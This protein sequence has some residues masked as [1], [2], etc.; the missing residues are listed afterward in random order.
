LGK[1][2]GQSRQRFGYL[3]ENTAFT[4]STFAV[5]LEEFG[6]ISAI[7]VIGLWIYF[8]FKGF[9]I[10]QNAP[11]T[12][13]KLIA[14]GITIWL[15]LQALLNIAANIGIIPITG[16][17]LPFFTYG[18]SSTIVTFIS[19]ALLLNIS[20]YGNKNLKSTKNFYGKIR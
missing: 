2:F 8:L 9:Q 17:P 20:R 3:V 10:A 1:G 13:G 14:I 15:T 5:V 7:I 12:Q 4:D 16:L 19:I 18:G 6:F 11:D